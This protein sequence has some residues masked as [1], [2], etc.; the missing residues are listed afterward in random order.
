MIEVN[1]PKDFA[2]E[3]NSWAAQLARSIRD[4]EPKYPIDLIYTRAYAKER[5]EDRIVV[6]N[7]VSVDTEKKWREF[8]WVFVGLPPTKGRGVSS[9][10]T[11]LAERVLMCIYTGLGA[12]EIADE[13]VA[14]LSNEKSA[15]RFLEG[16]DDL[17]EAVEKYVK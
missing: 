4:D 15:Y 10:L 9:V 12:D 11:D 14:T 13:L 16:I 6:Q 3:H 7:S 2:E 8:Q 1:E 17:R 5:I